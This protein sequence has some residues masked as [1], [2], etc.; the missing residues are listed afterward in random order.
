MENLQ[1]GRFTRGF[2]LKGTLTEIKK[3]IR[4]LTNLLSKKRE[5][6]DAKFSY[7]VEE[8]M[9]SDFDLFTINF[10]GRR[11]LSE[12]E[13]KNENSVLGVDE[14]TMKILYNRMKDFVFEDDQ[15]EP[16]N[17]KNFQKGGKNTQKVI[18]IVKNC[19]KFI[20]N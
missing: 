17:S 18:G 8:K 20:D 9:L 1:N 4:E 2:D 3:E 15:D 19:I 14:K 10:F 6:F 5:N 13:E 11:E 16:Q 7:T 12:F